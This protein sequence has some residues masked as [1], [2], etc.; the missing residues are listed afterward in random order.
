MYFALICAG[1]EALV[2]LVMLIGVRRDKAI[3][4]PTHPSTHPLLDEEERD[5][6]SGEESKTEEKEEK[7]KSKASVGR[8]LALSRPER[9]LI[10]LGKWVG[11]W[12]GG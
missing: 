8:L 10:V 1:L 5:V 9:G 6:E 11:G 3:H 4:P 7:K 2:S 12:V